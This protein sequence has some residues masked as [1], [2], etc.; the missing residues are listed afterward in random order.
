[1]KTAGAHAIVIGASMGGLVA[2][3]AL[4]GPYARVTILDRDELPSDPSTR[5]GVPQGR[6]VH[7]LLARGAQVLDDMFPG[8]LAELATAGV[9]VIRDFEQAHLTVSGS[10]FTKPTWPMDPPMYTPSRPFLEARVRSRVRALTGVEILDHAEVTGLLSTPGGDRVTGVKVYRHG[11]ETAMTADLVVDAT[12]RTGRAPVWLADLGYA[13]AGEEKLTVDL[14]YAT[15]HIRLPDT[16]VAGMKAAL[17]GPKAGHA[18]GL[19][20]AV[21]E[22]GHVVLTVAGYGKDSPPT[23]DAGFDAYVASIATPAMTAALAQATPLGP[24][25]TH[26]YPA[27]LR[28]RYEKLDRMPDGFL[29]FGDA[30]CSFNPLYGQGMTVSALQ[31]RALRTCLVRGKKGSA[32]LGPRFYKASRKAVDAAWMSA[33]GEDLLLPEIEGDRTLQVRVA[34]AHVSRVKR[35]A[36]V[37]PVVAET[38][39]RVLSFLDP[40]TAFFTPDILRRMY[41]ASRASRTPRPA[42]AAADS[43][44]PALQDAAHI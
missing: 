40:P 42:E 44:A 37:D 4:L 14:T 33:I 24:V 31:A 43:P 38:F 13:P 9:P 2:A 10:T 25:L 32:D 23:D 5:K 22:D 8:F 20:F 17:V 19:A 7:V 16:T 18:R 39:L 3:R 29:V 36:E 34:N 27:S 6:H 15:R 11:T 26:R 21:V 35:A 1:M 28:R 12:G 30:L 41:R